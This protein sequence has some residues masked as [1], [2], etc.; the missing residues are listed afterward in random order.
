MKSVKLLISLLPFFLF[1]QSYSPLGESRVFLNS[2]LNLRLFPSS[3]N[4]YANFVSLSNESAGLLYKFGKK[5]GLFVRVEGNSILT[6]FNLTRGLW[7]F[8]V[9]GSYSSNFWTGILAVGYSTP[10]S[11]IDLSTWLED[12]DFRELNLKYE[13]ELNSQKM[14]GVWAKLTRD[15]VSALIDFMVAPTDNR[16]FFLGTGGDSKERIF[17]TLGGHFPVFNRIFMEISGDFIYEKDST[18]VVKRWGLGFEYD[19]FLGEFHLNPRLLG[20]APYFLT[21]NRADFT[22]L[23]SVS[24]MYRFH[25]F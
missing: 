6:A 22:P 15:S 16:I 10:F 5:R 23:I 18:Y 14:A 4:G 7:D 9:L 11:R 13:K 21:G 8:G 20:Y 17:I 1:A 3:I 24:F 19:D 25:T 2:F 12:G